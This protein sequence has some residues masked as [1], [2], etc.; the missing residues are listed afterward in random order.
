M[1]AA[2][3]SPPDPANRYGAIPFA[4]PATIELKGLSA[5]SN[6]LVCRRRHGKYAVVSEKR[7][8]SM[9]HAMTSYVYGCGPCCEWN[10][11]HSSLLGRM[12]EA[13]G[14]A[15]HDAL[16]ECSE[17]GSGDSFLAEIRKLQPYIRLPATSRH[18]TSIDPPQSHLGYLVS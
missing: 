9:C 6:A 4:F 10:S 17:N 8:L 12:A 16:D 5:L 7:L 15:L 1:V 14:H 13:M 3:L 11:R 2:R 18:L